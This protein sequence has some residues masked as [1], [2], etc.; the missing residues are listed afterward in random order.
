MIKKATILV[1]GL[2][3]VNLGFCQS[4]S[5]DVIG[6]SGDHFVGGGAQISWTIGETVTETYTVSNSLLTQGFHQ[7]EIMSVTSVDELDLMTEVRIYPNPVFESLNLEFGYIEDSYIY[8][9]HDTNGKLLY[10]S[11]RS[12]LHHQVIDMSNYP[13][14]NYIL[15]II[16]DQS[17]PKTY[18]I[19]K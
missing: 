7:P 13:H 15:K 10:S 12:N 11:S 17:N 9:I 5:Q 18:K 19:V 6:T 4:I 8:N 3:T 16:F 2:I 14:G 1:L